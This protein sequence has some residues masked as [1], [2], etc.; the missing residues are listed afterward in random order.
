[1]TF[2]RSLTGD[3]ER[4]RN[5]QRKEGTQPIHKSAFLQNE[6]IS[7]CDTCLGGGL[8]NSTQLMMVQ[9]MFMYHSLKVRC[10]HKPRSRHSRTFH[11]HGHSARREREI[12]NS[13][14]RRTKVEFIFQKDSTEK[15]TLRELFV[16]AMRNSLSNSQQCNAPGRRQ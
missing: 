10:A 4:T 13:L 14:P 8:L 5:L 9:C 2:C 15:F 7:M 3:K 11:F 1:M 12:I 6:R 16:I